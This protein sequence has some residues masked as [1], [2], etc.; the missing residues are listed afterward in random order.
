MRRLIAESHGVE[1]HEL[2]SLEQARDA[3]PGVWA[4]LQGDDGGQIYAVFPVKLI[5]CSGA[6]LVSLLGELDAHYWNDR[7]MASV[8]Y[9]RLDS[10]AEIAGGMGGGLAEP[11]GWIH[12]T[13]V[14]DG[15]EPRI[16]AAVSGG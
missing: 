11:H 3:V 8:S 14:A 5:R 12:P 9:E 13:L 16:R 6:E 2:D 1:F 7:S 10:G 4:I 15:L